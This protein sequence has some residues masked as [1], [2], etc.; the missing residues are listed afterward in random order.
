MAKARDRNT[1]ECFFVN[2]DKNMTTKL[3]ENGPGVF[4]CKQSAKIDMDDQ[5]DRKVA[6]TNDQKAEWL[7]YIPH[8]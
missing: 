1:T 6:Y 4:K 7:T 5:L 2:T 3:A 8:C